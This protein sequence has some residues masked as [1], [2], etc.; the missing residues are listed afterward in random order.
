ME[1][2]VILMFET[3]NSSVS[4]N[5]QE[6]EKIPT[7]LSLSDVWWH[8]VASQAQVKHDLD[9]LSNDIFNIDLQI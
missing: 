1:L 4:N 5:C 7:N 2:L 9:K 3:F 6:W 8:G